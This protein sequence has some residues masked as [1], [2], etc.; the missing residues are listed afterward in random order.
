MKVKITSFLLSSFIAVIV[1]AI[2]LVLTFF[3]CVI[4]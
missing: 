3:I 1:S 4:A 2:L